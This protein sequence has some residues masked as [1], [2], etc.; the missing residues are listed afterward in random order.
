[1]TPGPLGLLDGLISVLR[2]M[3]QLSDVEVLDAAGP[4]RRHHANSLAE[5]GGWD[6]KMGIAERG[7]RREPARCERRSVER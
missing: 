4:F 6:R 7:I 2:D 1:M 3:G 5:T